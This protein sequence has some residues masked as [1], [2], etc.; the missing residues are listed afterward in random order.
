MP[1]RS[2]LVLSH[3]DPPII[4]FDIPTDQQ[5]LTL[6]GRHLEDCHA[7]RSQPL[8]TS[9]ATTI[10]QSSGL[11]SPQRHANLCPA[12]PCIPAE[13]CM[14]SSHLPSAEACKSSSRLASSRLALHPRRGMHIVVPLTL[15]G[16]IQIFIPLSLASLWRHANFC[17]VPPLLP[18]LR[19][20]PQSLIIAFLYFYSS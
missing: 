16:G 18:P 13:V 10:A 11:A 9:F 17:Q 6:T 15:C 19:A 3:S 1:T 4:P 7:L 14:S 8:V 12:Y 20:Q 2:I 5:C